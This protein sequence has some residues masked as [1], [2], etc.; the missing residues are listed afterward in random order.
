MSVLTRKKEQRTCLL[1]VVPLIR[2]MVPRDGAGAAFCEHTDK[3]KERGCE[4]GLVRGQRNDSNVN[5]M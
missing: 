5:V 3:K 4:T 2:V 1:E